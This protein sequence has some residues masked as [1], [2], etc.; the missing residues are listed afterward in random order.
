MYMMYCIYNT[1]YVTNKC[2]GKRN[3]H[4]NSTLN[5]VIFIAEFLYSPKMFGVS[6]IEIGKKTI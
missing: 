1:F 4:R 2:Q 3:R 6:L 5:I